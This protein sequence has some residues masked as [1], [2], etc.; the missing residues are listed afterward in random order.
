[1]RFNTDPNKAVPHLDV[2]ADTGNFTYAVYQMPPGEHYMAAG[3]NCSWPEFLKEWSR[4]TGAPAT[5]TQVTD[6]EMIATVEDHQFGI[7]VTKM[8]AYMSD[9]GYDGGMD[10]LYAE[11]L[12]KVCTY[13]PQILYWPVWPGQADRTR[14]WHR[15]SHDGPGAVF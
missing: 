3:A 7:E 12:R 14:G 1:M 9:P 11:D 10:L 5:Y 13:D 2:N 6:D 8:F 4:H 15:L